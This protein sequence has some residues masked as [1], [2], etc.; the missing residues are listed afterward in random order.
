MEVSL[1]PNEGCSAKGKKKKKKKNKY[2]YIYKQR[3]ITR[4][5]RTTKTGICENDENLQ[6]N[7]ENR[8]L[9]KHVETKH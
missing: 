3:K 6:T 8:D 1:G 5:V 7:T 4:I 2:I 9:M